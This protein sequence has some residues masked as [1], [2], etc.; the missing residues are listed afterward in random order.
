MDYQTINTGSTTLRGFTLIAKTNGDP[1]TS[2]TVNWYLKALTGANAGKWWQKSDESWSAGE[3]ANEME[4]QADGHWTC[5]PLGVPTSASPFD[6]GV[7][8]VEYAKE[9]G[10]LHVPSARLIRAAYTPSADSD[11][12]VDLGS[13]LGTP[14]QADPGY[15]RLDDDGVT[16][17]VDA[18]GGGVGDGSI[19]VN[20]DYGGVDALAFKTNLDIGIDNAVVKAF[21]KSD[22]DAENRTAM[23]VKGQTTTDVDGRFTK[24]LM[25]DP[26]V[27]VIQVFKQGSYG[28]N[29]VEITVA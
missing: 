23:Y 12:R 18:L 8:F 5:D 24:S 6:D 21:L 17:I 1:I 16:V 9:S 15:V 20:H 19:E 3:V 13:I 2:G 26:E 14:S 11:N 28:P 4:H 10:D 22:Y 7:A 25:L 29:T 27:Y